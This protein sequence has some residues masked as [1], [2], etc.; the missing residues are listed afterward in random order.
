MV[1]L[2]HLPCLAKIG[3]RTDGRK[4]VGVG[5]RGAQ[6]CGIQG[7]AAIIAT[8]HLSRCSSASMGEK[9]GSELLL[10]S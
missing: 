9:G 1:V 3:G 7:V 8:A 10:K 6:G 2:V 5:S 4:N